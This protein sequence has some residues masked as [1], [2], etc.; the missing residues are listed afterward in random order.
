MLLG[1]PQR[2]T[3]TQQEFL[4]RDGAQETPTQGV[5]GGDPCLPLQLALWPGESPDSLDFLGPSVKGRSQS[6]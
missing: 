4:H 2:S 6:T 3:K 5:S 1:R